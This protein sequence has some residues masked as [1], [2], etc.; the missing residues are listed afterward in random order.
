[1]ANTAD[2]TRCVD[3]ALEKAEI[4]VRFD[5]FETT[6]VLNVTARPDGAVRGGTVRFAKYSNY[7]AFIRK[8]ELRVF[9][10]GESTLKTPLA[11]ITLDPK[12]DTGIDWPVP[13]DAGLDAVQYLLRVYDGDG[14]FDE[15]TPKLL[16]LLDKPR[17]LGDEQAAAREDL[18]GYGENHR[19]L[20][21]IPVHGGAVT[22]NGE[23]LAPGTT[24]RCSAAR[25]RSMPPA[26]FAVRQILPAGN[27]V[28]GVVTTGP[29]G[30]RAEF[31]R[32]LYIPVDD[33][34]YVALADLTI[35]A[36]NVKGP[37]ELVTGDDSKRYREEVYVDGR[38]AFYLKGKIKGETLL[39]A[40]ADTR[41]QPF[42]Q[43]FTNFNGKDPRYL[44]RRIDPNAY[45][46]VYGDDSTLVED[47]PTQGKFY[48]KLQKNDSHVLWGS[49]HTS[50]TGTDL[51]N[52]SRALYGAQGR[53]RSMDTTG[54]GEKQTQVEA[55]AADPGT[56]ASRE[57][58]RGTGGSLYYLRNQDVLVGSE[59]LRRE[60]RDKDSGIVLESTTLVYGQDYEINYLQGRVVLRAPLSA[61]ADA[62]TLVRTGTLSGH[63]VY[64]VAGYEY[65][66]GVTAI[67]Q[68]HR[69]RARLALAERSP[70][71][72]RDRLQAGRARRPA[73]DRR[74]RPHPEVQARYLYKD[75]R[76]GL[77]GP[78]ERR[79][80]VA[81]RRLRLQSG[82]ADRRPR[83]RGGRAACRGGD[84]SQGDRRQFAPRHAV[85]LLAGARGRLLRAGTAHQRSGRSGR[86]AGARLCQR[87]PRNC[88]CG[89]TARTAAARACTTPPK[90]APPTRSRRA[91]A[92]AWR[93]ATTIAETAAAAGASALLAET[94]A[95]TD[96]AAKLA[97]HPTDGEKQ[98]G[99]WEIY[100]LVQGTAQRDATRSENDRY[101]AGGHYQAN[102]RVTLSGE[103]TDGDGGVGGKLGADY[104]L[105][106]RSSV[107]LNYLLDSNRSD[108]GYRGRTGTLTGGAKTR[109]SDSLSVYA[110]ERYQ[111]SD[112][113]P[114]RPDPRL[115]PRP[116]GRRPLDLRPEDGAGHHFRSG[117]RR[118]RPHRGV[119]VGRLP[120][121]QGEV[122]QRGRVP[123][124]GRQR[125]RRARHLADEE[126]PRLPDHAGL[127]LPRA[128]QFRDQRCRRAQHRRRR[129]RRAWC[130]AMPIARC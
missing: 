78:G 47:A 8:A 96:V 36:N 60:V 87:Q 25:C 124:R 23:Q 43:L 70:A 127:A 14:R 95:R 6:P 113:G 99:R 125:H 11:I 38:L 122:R 84:R 72:R 64:L 13:A 83:H 3:V 106:D 9:A 49:F 46:P 93:C 112:G 67:E 39:T 44:L 129:L 1:M 104:R 35:G 110:E 48:V 50:L 29:D 4:Q 15:T 55:F 41:E 82:A 12:T 57:E 123:R 59:R 108:T 53:Y 71:D 130:W 85:G 17:P 109:Y 56:L 33:W 27:H 76:R 97:Y 80:V 101:G 40:S 111:N 107:Y 119:G 65:T 19:G 26:R 100:G 5:G 81:E 75:R 32:H 121:R 61:T 120:A 21:N 98:P 73:A 34:F 126:Q 37:A 63:P 117:D 114:V 62:A 66:P 42:D 128:P 77:A 94:G 54:F 118:S 102:N 105:S 24:C 116:R 45:Y 89:S 22:V 18:I 20:K 58:F 69:R 115:R 86:P 30:Q 16:R 74:Q 10:A 103:V 91:S 28:V 31:S 68:S 51:V 52:Y 90:S 88:R 2:V 92:P 7:A 79:A